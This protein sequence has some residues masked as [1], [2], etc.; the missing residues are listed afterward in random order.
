MLV[1]PGTG[2]Q[3][4]PPFVDVATVTAPV[5]QFPGAHA[6]TGGYMTWL[7]RLQLRLPAL[8]AW[9]D[10]STGSCAATP[11][12][13]CSSSW[14]WLRWPP[15]RA[16]RPRRSSS[17]RP[18]PAP[19]AGR[20]PVGTRL[21]PPVPTAS[22]QVEGD[23]YSPP[24]FEFDG[25]NGGD[26]T[27]GVSGDTITVSYRRTGEQSTLSVLATLMGIEFNETNDDFQ[28]TTEGLVEYFNEN[29]QFYGRKIELVPFEA[30]AGDA[31]V[32][33]ELVGGGQEGANNDGLKAGQEINAFADITAVTQ[34]YA[35]ALG[36]QKVVNFG[37]PYMSREWFTERR[38]YSW[39]LATDCSV[40]A[41]AA[42]ATGVKQ[43]LDRP[44]I[45]AGGE[46]KDQPRR[47]AVIS[48]SNPQYQDCTAAGLAV[49]KEAGKEPTLVTDYV[50]DLGRIPNQAKSIASQ[51]VSQN[52]TTVS[53]FCDP[54][55]LQNLTVRDRSAGPAAGVDG[56]GRGLRRSRPHRPG[57]DE[58][59]RPVDPRL[60]CHASRR[61][62]DQGGEPR[63]QGVQVGAPRRGAIGDR[64]RPLLPALPAGPRHPDGRPGADARDL[65]DRHVHLPRARPA[66]PA[67][68][69]TSRSR[70]RPIVEPARSGGTPKRSRRS[71]ARRA[72]TCSTA[73]ATGSTR[74]RRASR[75]CSTSD[76]G[77]VAGEQRTCS[78][79]AGCA[80]LA[81][82][83]SGLLGAYDRVA[84]ASC[85]RAS[86]SASAPA[87][88]PSASCSS[89]ARP[90]S[91]TSPTAPW[92]PS[93]APWP[94][95]LRSATWSVSW[96]LAA[97]I[98][99]AAGIVVGLLVEL[100][101]IRR[102]ANSPR[103]VLT[104]ATIGLAQA[105][106]GLAL[107]LPDWFG[108]EPSNPSFSTPLE[109]HDL[110]RRPG[111]PRRQRPRAGRGG[112]ARSRR[113]RVGSC[114]APK[115]ASPCGAW[116]RTSTGPG[117]SASPSTGS[118][119]CCGPSPAGSPP[120]RSCSR[121]RPKAWRSTPRP[122]RRLLLAPLA[123]AVIVGMRSI[124]G[125][126]LAGVALEVMD[127]LVQINADTRAPGPSS[128]SSP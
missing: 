90:A 62:A 108:T 120:S 31:A 56:C 13:Q 4:F 71:T 102:F 74:S 54:F 107:F 47:T 1:Q 100:L 61:T 82:S 106:G 14:W 18:R 98:A 7:P 22:V 93:P 15:S 75:R 80:S 12:W 8:V 28:R 92:A 30:S 48:P 91:S 95:G 58:E 60:R 122:A 42:S 69:T 33:N 10:R 38:P 39:S 84:R 64:R 65:R 127:Q 32:T 111:D 119:C 85:S 21:S 55:M 73:S 128:P 89:T 97:P 24:C 52:I 114:S 83:S 41:E 19:K 76:A 87:S 2:E 45:Y 53:C 126:F 103:L 16:A 117:S 77:E 9:L 26:T 51:I 50:L 99:I 68:G 37:A 72:R 86:P 78:S 79:P 96:F 105:L 109:R 112:S 104:V 125:A 36:R 3:T 118:T 88:W 5:P 116:P 124:P 27:K 35:E 123:A 43:I 6:V 63:L 70:T 94:V 11:R 44:A 81:S 110:D 115:P 17:P 29:F 40:V 57:A 34:P 59:V 23:S 113:A 20:P 49:T 67:R 46:L 101:V 25:D 121:H 66:P